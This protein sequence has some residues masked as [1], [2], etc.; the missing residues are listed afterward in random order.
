MRYVVTILLVILLVIVVGVMLGFIFLDFSAPENRQL[1]AAGILAWYD[2]GGGEGGWDSSWSSGGVSDTAYYY[3]EP[4]YYAGFDGQNSS[5]GSGGVESWYDEPDPYYYDTSYYG[6]SYVDEYYYVDDY[7]YNS[8]SG[9]GGYIRQTQQPWYVQS[10]PGFGQMAQQIIPG[11]HPV[12]AP[13]PRPPVVVYSQP[14]CWISAQPTSVQYGGSS[15]LQWSSFNA[16]RA[17]LTDFGTV[18]TSGTR[19]VQNIRNDR[20]FVLTVSGQG[21][22]GS[23][24]TRISVRQGATPSCVIAVNPSAIS[25]GASASLGWWSENATSASLSGFGSVSLMGGRYVSP[26]QTTTYTLTVRNA[27]GQSNMCAA[28]LGVLP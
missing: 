25:R 17:T 16:T 8:G 22:T 21:G 12:A 1:S 27:S 18:P 2:E 28:E 11:L 19:T 13:S 9:G 6:N 15:A 20:M 24:Y 4:S 10:F 26:Q 3:D 23:C 14:S 5:G 7:Y